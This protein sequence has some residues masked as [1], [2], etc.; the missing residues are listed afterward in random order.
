VVS[1][2]QELKPRGS[3]A[4]SPPQQAA[5][6]VHTWPSSR[7]SASLTPHAALQAPS[8]P[9]FLQSTSAGVHEASQRPAARQQ[10]GSAEPHPAPHWELARQ[11]HSGSPAPLAPHVPLARQQSGSLVPQA[12]PHAPSATHAQ[13]GS[14]V[15][16]HVALHVPSAAH[17]QSGSGEG[18]PVAQRPSAAQVAGSFAARK[19]SMKAST[20]LS[21]SSVPQVAFP[22]EWMPTT[23]VPRKDG[24]PESPTQV[25]ALL[26][27]KWKVALCTLLT[28]SNTERR[29]PDVAGSLLARP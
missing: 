10:S 18:Q 21:M 15:A 24:P 26:V 16:P 12:A 5:A 8:A 11:R 1:R 9:Q 4:H 22:R 13:S 7:Q 6:S 28:G 14:G 3:A 29:V 2:V 23:C 27:P 20:R 19:A 17:G 25:P